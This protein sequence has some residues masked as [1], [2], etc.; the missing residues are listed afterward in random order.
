MSA[1][2]RCAPEGVG[3]MSPHSNTTVVLVHGAFSENAAW[4]GVI[5]R[6]AQDGVRAFAASNPLRGVAGDAEYVSDIV[7]AVDGPVVLVGHGYGGFALTQAAGAV[8]N[9]E[10]LVYVA[11][12]AP[13]TGE[14][15][16]HLTVLHPGS[17]LGESV[18]R[19]PLSSGETDLAIR[20]DRFHPQFCADVDEATAT[21]MAAT[22]RAISERAMNEPL[23]V[24]TPAWRRIPSWFVYGTQDKTIPEATLASLAIRAGS[25]GT[26]RVEDAS[27]AVAVSQPEAVVRSILAAI[28]R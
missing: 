27:H 23:S 12:F 25:H 20:A 15:M 11:A 4:N 14:S 17:T 16:A 8:A 9:V 5:R 7:R 18:A 24:P 2:E 3:I 19:M 10:A 13:D 6:L 26:T 22:Q 1:P 28:A 21:L